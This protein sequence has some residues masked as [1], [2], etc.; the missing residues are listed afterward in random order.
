MFNGN[1]SL[2]SMFSLPWQE[3]KTKKGIM[4]NFLQQ[5]GVTS[6]NLPV[7]SFRTYII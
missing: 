1:P 7:R 3:K 4:D 5:F 6:T 2:K